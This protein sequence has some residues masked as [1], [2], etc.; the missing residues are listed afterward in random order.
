VPIA[1]RLSDPKSGRPDLA[2]Y[3]ALDPEVT[4]LNH[5]AYGACPWP[6]LRAQDEWRTRMERQP[7][8]FN[9][10]DLEGHLDHA[11]GRLADFLHADPDDMALV[12]NATTGVNTIVAALDFGPGDEI[13]T[14]DHE[15]NACLNAIRRV[16]E[17]TGAQA[18]VAAVP[19][20]VSSADDVFEAIVDRASE[21]TRLAVL[22]HVTSPTGLVFPIARIVAALAERG[23][24]TVV[25]GAHTPGMLPLDIT[26]LG[27]AY[28]AGNCHK[29][30]CAPKGAGF[31]HVRRDRQDRIRPLVTS[32]GANSPRHNRSR[33]RL[34]FDWTGTSDPTAYLSIPAALDFFA[35]QVPGGWSEV[36]ARNHSLALTGRQAL[37]D[38]L[39]GRPAAPDEMIGSIAAVELSNEISPGPAALAADADPRATYPLDPLH[40]ALIYGDA[41]EVPVYAWPHTP[42][43]GSPRR[44]LLRVSA[45][46]YNTPADYDRLAAAL[47]ARLDRR[48]IEPHPLAVGR[49]EAAP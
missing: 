47:V 33:F 34:E 5:G 19:F 22:S 7:T 2:R 8:Q 42:A 18:V 16:A 23:I 25:D 49:I 15:Y 11:R 29:W 39:G 21:H 44:R 10:T 12:P 20:P 6:V 17:R 26:S 43:D 32:H 1:D 13:L 28:Y 37:L 38:A 24:D 9:G 45:Q 3:W 40:E 36:M 48:A 14:T 41:I 35:T 46:L 4:Y 30:L 27:A 31:V